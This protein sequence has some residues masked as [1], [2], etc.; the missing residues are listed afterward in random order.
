L[1]PASHLLKFKLAHQSGRS[2]KT[3]N[4]ISKFIFFAIEGE[5]G[6]FLEGVV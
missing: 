6:I 1:K 4:D 2:R 5:I 3:T